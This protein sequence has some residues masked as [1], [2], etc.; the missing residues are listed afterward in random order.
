MGIVVKSALDSASEHMN[1]HFPQF[2]TI[3]TIYFT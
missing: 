2:V 1:G 3:I